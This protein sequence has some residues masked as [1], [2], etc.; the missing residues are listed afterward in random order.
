MMENET[1]GLIVLTRQDL[2]KDKKDKLTDEITY[3]DFK[4]NMLSTDIINNADLIVFIDDNTLGFLKNKFGL[5]S[6]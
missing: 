5:W 2:A 6:K 4:S 3:D 1:S